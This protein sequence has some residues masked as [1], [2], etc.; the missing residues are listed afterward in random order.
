MKPWATRGGVYMVK[1]R[2]IWGLKWVSRILPPPVGG[3]D[4]P[5]DPCVG[6]DP[7]G[8]VAIG[9][10]MRSFLCVSDT[11]GMVLALAE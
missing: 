3:R 6:W 1:N 7:S 9:M 8:I 11:V 5:H 10:K 2:V 4:P